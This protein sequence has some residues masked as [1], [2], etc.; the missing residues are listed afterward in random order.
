MGTWANH[1]IKQPPEVFYK[2]GVHKNF[3]KFTGKYVSRISLLIQYRL[4]AFPLNFPKFSRTPSLQ[5]IFG[6]LLLRN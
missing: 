3:A 6:R 1:M 5:N 4:E 2:K